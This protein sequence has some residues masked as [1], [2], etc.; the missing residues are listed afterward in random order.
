MQIFKDGKEIKNAKVIYNAFGSPDTV[1][2]DGVH[3][4][5]SAFEFKEPK[6]EEK[7]KDSEEAPKSTKRT[8]KKR[9]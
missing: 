4:A 9:K 5:P 2:I 3:Y 1:R 6:V 8:A 7:T